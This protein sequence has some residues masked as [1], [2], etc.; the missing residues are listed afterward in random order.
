VAAKKE[1]SFAQCFL[2]IFSYVES[3][4]AGKLNVL[5]ADYNDE[6][7]K[8]EDRLNQ[9][10]FGAQLFTPSDNP[11]YSPLLSSNVSRQ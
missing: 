9:T 11:L 5:A 2:G 10:Q 3:M 7:K 6:L 1:F 4:T 8:H